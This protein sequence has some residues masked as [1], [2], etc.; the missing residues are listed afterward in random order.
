MKKMK[1][2]QFEKALMKK[3]ELL[4]LDFEAKLAFKL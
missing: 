3:T 2:K 1:K 4:E